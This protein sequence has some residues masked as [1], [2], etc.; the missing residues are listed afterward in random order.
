LREHCNQFGHRGR[1]H[2]GDWS[3]RIFENDNGLWIVLDDQLYALNERNVDAIV[4]EV[5]RRSG[6]GDPKPV[7]V[8]FPSGRFITSKKITQT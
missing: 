3:S 5:E 6:G 7:L 8:S 2:F 1:F 4:E